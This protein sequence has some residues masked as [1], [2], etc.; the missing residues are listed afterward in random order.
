MISFEPLYEL[1]TFLQVQLPG[2]EEP[3]KHKLQEYI[4]KSDGI[5]YGFD[6]LKIPEADVREYASI[7][8]GADE[9]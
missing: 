2:Q 9:K 1:E 3:T 6:G 7:P 8:P 5:W 4:V